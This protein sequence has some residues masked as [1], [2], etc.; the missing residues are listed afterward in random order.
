[1]PPASYDSDSAGLWTFVTHLL[2][3]AHGGY[4]RQIVEMH[5]E[6]TVAMEIDLPVV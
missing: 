6:D 1:M 2:G 4:W 5:M 3:K